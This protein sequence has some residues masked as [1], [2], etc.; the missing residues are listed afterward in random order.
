MEK[1]FVFV[2]PGNKWNEMLKCMLNEI[3]FMPNIKVLESIFPPKNKILTLVRRLH[4]SKKLNSIF[5]LPFKNKWKLT[6]DQ[7]EYDSGKQYNIFFFSTSVPAVGV[8]SRLEK[9]RS[10][11]HIKYI[12]YAIDAWKSSALDL[13]REYDKLI[14][15]DNIITFDNMDAKSFNLN[16]Y[17]I[18]FSVLSNKQAV[19][20]SNIDLIYVGLAK[21]RLDELHS[22]FKEANDLLDNPYFRVTNVPKKKMLYENVIYNKWMSYIDMVEKTIESNCILEILYKTQT[23]ATLR[24]Y[25]AVCYNKKLLT[26]NK[27]VVNLPF[28]NPDYIHVFE[29]PEDIDWNWVKER[30]PVD[31]HYDGCF[32]P[33]HLIDKI[34]ELEEEKERNELGKVEAD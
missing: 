33:T 4:F 25:E 5:S 28:Y 3:C 18:P 29:K 11:H 24:Y 12:L 23:A 10:R 17:P 26:N 30:I 15:F 27:N 14:K 34:I 9:L 6:L 19:H 7:I 16:Y 1:I 20:E 32:S 13:A 8:E 21:D 2:L 22:I 31:Y